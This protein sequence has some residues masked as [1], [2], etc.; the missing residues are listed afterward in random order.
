MAGLEGMTEALLEYRRE[1]DRLD[2]QIL[3]VL[4]RRLA[5]CREVASHKVE[6]GIPMMQTNRVAEVKARAVT[7]GKN[8]GLSE[9]F[10]LSLF[11]IVIEEACRIED[12][13]IRNGTSVSVKDCKQA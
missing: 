9:S 12:E 4:S 8:R 7:Q 6:A 5:I 3:E 1:L 11:E 2:D 13:I 10:V